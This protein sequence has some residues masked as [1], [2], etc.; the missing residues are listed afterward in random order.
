MATA[1]EENGGAQ[2]LDSAANNGLE[3]LK[4][5]KDRADPDA[6]T[7]VTDF[8]DFTEYLPADMTRSLTQ[9]G[10]LDQTYA[11]AST[12][13]HELTTTWGKLPT[14]TGDQRPE[15][16]KLRAE[17]SDHLR[18]ATNSRQCAYDEAERMHTNVVRHVNK[19]KIMLAKL[20]A[21]HE[22]WPTAEE[23][24]SPV[25]SKSPQMVRAPKLP[26]RVDNNNQKVAAHRRITVPGDVLAPYE[27]DYN[28]YTSSTDES[29]EEE[30][31]VSPVRRTTT[32]N[33]RIKLVKAPKP[34][35]QK[36]P[37]TPKPLKPSAAGS[38]N[39]N[40]P[41][42]SSVA[43]PPPKPPPD[44]AEPGSS[45]A[46]WL[47]LTAW[48]LA[49]L[50]KRMKKNAQ[51]VPSET[52]IAR[53]LKTLG[54]GADAYHAA[55]RDA[56]E[57]GKPFEAV[58]PSEVVD[59]ESAHQHPP[60]GALSANAL[61]QDEVQLSNRGMKLNEAKKLKREM[62]AKQAV[63]EAEESARK[64]AD[65]ARA[66]FTNEASPSVAEGSQ[67]KSRDTPGQNQNSQ[68]S[69]VKAQSKSKAKKRKRDSMSETPVGEKA[70][71]SEGQVSA[72]PAAQT[73]S[74]PDKDKPQVKRTKTE[75][76]VPLPQFAQRP[77]SVP[78]PLPAPS[79]P[80]E[81]PVPVP[82]LAKPAPAQNVKTQTPVPVPV[83]VPTS[84]DTSI[85]AARTAASSSGQTSPVPPSTVTTTVPT[86]PP[87]ETPIPPPKTSTTPILPPVRDIP[88]RETRQNLQ[89]NLQNLQPISTNAKQSNSRGNTPI[90]TPT[91]SQAAE[92]QSA[93]SRRPSSRGKAA[94][95]EP[96]PTLAAERPRRASTARNT[97]APEIRQPSKRAKRP[98]PGVVTTKPGGGGT[99]AIGK[100]K[101]APRK[102]SRAPKKEQPELEV[103]DEVDDDGKPI[104]PNEQR[105][106]LCNRVSFGTMIQCENVDNCKYEWFH[107]ECVELDDIPART[108]KWYCPECRVALNIGGRGEVNSRGIKL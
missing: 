14:L 51:W 15:P 86:K 2:P 106:C 84:S 40:P 85:V 105:Y 99:S 78:P 73:P 45:D 19:N 8:L 55:K 58:D 18:R 100:R 41:A 23:Q 68:T 102:K 104:D 77:P 25:Q 57:N 94:S 92:P 76:P 61:T 11:D 63:E 9:I 46:P 101:A 16:G 22:N 1:E 54:R 33:P 83:P 4:E 67:D 74:Q 47:R 62:L 72:Q 48:E 24:K 96:P 30:I 7:T 38:D 70:Q 64:M 87:A 13:I 34:P 35:K 98:A 50:R 81:T 39:A 31:A 95:Q 32:P 108:T 17:I 26:M 60:E 80:A 5:L 75:T 71:G 89:N 97:P 66:L 49:K 37:K 59:A 10:Q 88:K 12:K 28:A 3:S 79:A 91:Q 65:A 53:E 20:R 44:D 6:Q 69:Q 90:A 21:M 93:T 107:L 82:Q 29:S 27:V 52:M 43:G 103:E 36:A 42:P 56:E